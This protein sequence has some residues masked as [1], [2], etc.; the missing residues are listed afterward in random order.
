MDRYSFFCLS[1]SSSHLQASDPYNLTTA[2]SHSH[3]GHDLLS[4]SQ[5][6]KKITVLLILTKKEPTT[7]IRLISEWGRHKR[8]NRSEKG[9]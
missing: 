1:V 7:S 4:I 8:Q 3:N 9:T 6:L 5:T 2:V